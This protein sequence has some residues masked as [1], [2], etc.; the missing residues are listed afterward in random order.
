MESA[1]QLIA[2]YNRLYVALVIS[3]ILFALIGI[4]AAYSSSGSLS[5]T[6]CKK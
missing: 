6:Y 1:P 3:L 4:S 5:N 2:K